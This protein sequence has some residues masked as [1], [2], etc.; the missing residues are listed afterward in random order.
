MAAKT[1]AGKNPFA[2]AEHK[3]AAGGVIAP[4]PETI[5][6]A[7]KRNDVALLA[8]ILRLWSQNGKDRFWQL[9]PPGEARFALSLSREDV[10]SRLRRL[11]VRTPRAAEV[12]TVIDEFFCYV[13]EHRSVAW[14][15][16]IAGHPL[17][18][19]ESAGVRLLVNQTFRMIE[20]KAGKWETI[21]TWCERFFADD[22]EPQ[23]PYF[24][25]WLKLGMECIGRGVSRPGH[26]LAIAGPGDTGKSFLQSSLITPLLG[27]RE[28][29]PLPFLRDRD[30]FNDDVC[31]AEHQAIGEMKGCKLDGQSRAELGEALKDLAVNPR[32]RLRA[33]YASAIMVEPRRR[34]SV[35]LNDEPDKLKAF[36][37]LSP[38]FADK[39]LLLLCQ[40]GAIPIDTS[41]ADG[42]QLFGGRVRD[43]L[44]AF[45]HFLL[46]EWTIPAPLLEGEHAGRFGFR[47]YH[48]PA[49]VAE[50]FGQTPE[51]D[52]LWVI[53][54][55]P[56]LASKERGWMSAEDIREV[57]LQGDHAAKV[58][59]HLTF[60]GAM[61]TFLKRLE[62][63]FPERFSKRHTMRGNVW[64]ISEG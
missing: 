25:A 47:T 12:S 11:G 14:A 35:T 60:P 32:M 21:R 38:D 54:Q 43:E 36:P 39:V 45:A 58:S 10:K 46:H 3:L 44:P 19:I 23:L 61:G 59:K 4:S 37:A 18:V 2:A 28:G 50:L 64:L 9:P 40:P 48:H 26:I 63:K 33:Q 42:W 20:A 16:S 41:H 51:S 56:E 5:A 27:G 55:T 49:L 52:L 8:D 29:N 62:G 53:D 7:V 57:L 1:R 34:V 31:G 15:G 24:Y 30:A 13:Q 22:G 6:Q 17:G